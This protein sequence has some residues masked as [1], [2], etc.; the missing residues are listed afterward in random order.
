LHLTT[1]DGKRL[2]ALLN[3]VPRESVLI[4]PNEAFQKQQ[5]QA[6]DMVR[7]HRSSCSSDHPWLEHIKHAH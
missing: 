6:M 1:F 4:I 5:Q 7:M 2:Q 3:V